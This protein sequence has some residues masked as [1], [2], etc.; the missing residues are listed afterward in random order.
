MGKPEVCLG[1]YLAAQPFLCFFDPSGHKNDMK[2]ENEDR[3]CH[4]Q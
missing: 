3:S 4:Y 2:P 1:S